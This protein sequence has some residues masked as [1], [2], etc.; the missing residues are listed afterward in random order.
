MTVDRAGNPRWA[1]FVKRTTHQ[2]IEH[3]LGSRQDPGLEQRIRA[4]LAEELEKIA[5]V[6][7][8]RSS[9]TAPNNVAYDLSTRAD[10]ILKWRPDWTVILDLG[11]ET[12]PRGYSFGEDEDGARAEAEL[13][14][15]E[16]PE[17]TITVECQ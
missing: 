3:H 14:Q 1:D 9:L 16:Y 13:L 4:I 2:T 11:G 17:A 15:Q 12:Q 7:N 5:H 8:S 6:Y 10:A